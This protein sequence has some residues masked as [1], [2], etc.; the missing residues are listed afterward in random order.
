MLGEDE[1]LHNYMGVE[2]LQNYMGVEYLQNCMGICFPCDLGNSSPAHLYNI[3]LGYSAVIF[4]LG[5][6]L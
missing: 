5:I 1:Y 4:P 3:A 2:Y 6:A